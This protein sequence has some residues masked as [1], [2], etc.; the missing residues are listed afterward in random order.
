MKLDNG[1][2]II[3]N[4]EYHA[5]EGISR[6]QLMEIKRSPRHYWYKFHSGQYV[7]EEKKDFAIGNA[8][9]TMVLEP[10]SF[11]E[12]FAIMQDINR[13][14]NAGK[15]EY[16]EFVAQSH[17]MT[18]LSQEDFQLSKNIADA[19]KQ[20]ADAMYLVLDSRIENSIYFTHQL[21]GQQCK[22]RP[23]AWNGSIVIDLKT[24]KDASYRD[25]QSS[26]YKNGYF[27]QA[28]MMYEAMKSIGQ[29]LEKFV[30]IAVEKTPPF[31]VAI[32]ILD[33]YAIECGLQEFDR[34]MGLLC[35]CESNNKWQ[36]YGIQTL[37][38]PGWANF[39]ATLEI[40]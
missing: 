22:T 34:L 7:R 33:D 8:V 11:E 3:S 27:L 5:S 12:R 19:V 31:A 1:I 40:E 36:D 39:D 23:D 25:F 4:E 10:R 13:R 9:H 35:Q 38:V 20:N 24:T 18:I 30:F 2:H 21:T 37:T 17:G 6:S 16:K 28:G 15:E 14:T 32:Y 29:P 26:A